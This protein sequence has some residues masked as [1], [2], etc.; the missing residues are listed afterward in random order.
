MMVA[1]STSFAR[2]AATGPPPPPPLPLMSR[3]AALLEL[4]RINLEADELLRADD[5]PDT[6]PRRPLSIAAEEGRLEVEEETGRAE[7]AAA[8]VV[9]NTEG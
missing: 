4:G 2:P 1:F 3:I 8:R 9:D 7:A 6:D 5:D